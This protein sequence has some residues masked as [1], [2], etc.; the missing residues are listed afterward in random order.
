MPTTRVRWV[1][2]KQ[3]VGMDSN[4]HAVALS[5]DDQPRGIRPSEMLLIALAACTAVDVVEILRKKRTALDQLEIV[6]SGEQDSDPPW[7]YRRIHIQYRLGGKRLTAQ[8]VEQAIKLSEEKYCSVSATVRG[9]ADI[10]TEYHIVS[11]ED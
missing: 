6:A 11:D 1:S 3:F 8:A 10:T 7:P 2:G 9:V 5:G 4:N